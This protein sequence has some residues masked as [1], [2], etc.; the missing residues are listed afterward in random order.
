M[1]RGKLG[2]YLTASPEE[3]IVSGAPAA[4]NKTMASSQHPMSKVYYLG[5]EGQGV[6]DPFDCISFFNIDNKYAKASPFN[7][8][9]VSS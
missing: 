3:V 2:K 5:V 7:F 4:G 6:G 8:D 9:Y 1:L